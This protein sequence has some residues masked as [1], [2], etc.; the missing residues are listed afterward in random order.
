MQTFLPY[1][2]FEESARCLDYKRLG[3]Q[4]VEAKQ[5]LNALDPNY[6]G[7]GW[8]NHPA[9]LMWKG[10]EDCLKR[11]SNAMIKEWV[12]RG[13]NNTM[14]IYDTPNDFKLPPW[15]GRIELHKSHRMNLLRKDYNFYADYFPEE[16]KLT[17]FEIEAFPYWWPTEQE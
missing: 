14:E 6:D 3:K 8:V 12:K 16:S 7:K 17:T 5:I 10:Y 2:S 13:Y 9:T 4:R 1:R 11:Y 15:L